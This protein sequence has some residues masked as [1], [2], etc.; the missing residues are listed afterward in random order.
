MNR[1][2]ALVA[3][4]AASSVLFSC[5]GGA[6]TAVS[7][8]PAPMTI[9]GEDLVLLNGV[10]HTVNSA[11]PQAEA[12]AIRDGLIVFV[13]SN[14]DVKAFITPATQ[15]I[16]LNGRFVMPGIHD[17]H[18]H[19]MEAGSSV[20]TNCLLE[21]GQ[22][23]ENHIA[24]LKDCAPNQQGTEV[25]LGGGFS[26]FDMFDTDRLPVE[27]LD[28]AIPSRPALMLEE[29]SH[30]TWA[31]SRALADAGITA[32]SANPVGGVIDKDPVS[33]QPTGLLIDNAGDMLFH[34]ALS[35][36][37]S[38]AN[39]SELNFQGLL[40]IL[41]EMARFGITSAS[42]ARTYWQRDHLDVWRRME[43]ENRLTARIALGL[44]AYPELSDTQQIPALK[45]LF[46][47][48]PDGLL[49]VNQIKF[50]S[51][52][53]I[54]NG[55]SALLAPYTET[56][57]FTG[58]TGLNYFTQ[59]RLQQYITALEPVGFNMNI[60]AIGDRG[61]QEALNAVEG[62]VT[63]NRV[64]DRRHRITHVEM[65]DASDIP[66]FAQLGVI[67]DAQVAGDF[68][69]PG[70]ESDAIP[71]IGKQR[72]SRL[73]P[74]GELHDAG[75]KITLSSDYDVSTLSPFVGMENSLKRGANSLPNIQA[76][77]EAYTINAAFAMKQEQKVGSLEV[78]KEADLIVL[79]Q[80][81]LKVKVENISNTQVLL[82]LL[83]GESVFQSSRF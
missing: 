50:Y 25:V 81:I 28:D 40:L 16:D 75:A 27:I 37:R 56:P 78:G 38:R 13:G 55:T 70:G 32:A 67:A 20:T 35:P 17:V 2:H 47:E 23:L 48:N 39:L 58:S 29:T 45:A 3:L 49:Q 1:I 60:H 73:I 4:L 44:W 65:V 83:A 15:L 9:T 79:N 6:S 80:N 68:T 62:A 63:A 66:R 21:S 52:G 22:N 59:Q 74:L 51:D 11:Q 10:I 53:I 71:F 33:G 24:T 43:R 7:P 42:D 26:I 57:G 77:I 12:I 8:S 76:A 69:L 64:L 72:A 30:S 31:N 82:T 36:K 34:R 5:G 14:A 61:V 46:S 18:M 54:I 41:D 19:P